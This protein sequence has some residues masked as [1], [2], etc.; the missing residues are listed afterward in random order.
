MKINGKKISEANIE[1]IVIPREDGDIVFKAVAILDMTPFDKMVPTPKPPK[2]L[3]PNGG[4][5][6][7]MQDIAYVA[8][9][10]EYSIKRMGF[11]VTWSLLPHNPHI[12]WE[13]VKLTDP[14]SWKL[15]QPE[16]QES[17]FSDAEAGQIFTGVMIANSLND[18]KLTA[19][20][21]R[22]LADLAATSVKSTS[23]PAEQ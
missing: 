12:E 4:E 8:A 22:F 19:A 15:V 9:V 11:I 13:K 18:R 2:Q 17:G 23:L 20:R 1:Y 6:F 21:E 16:L 10:N 14:D 3:R 7:D 5:T